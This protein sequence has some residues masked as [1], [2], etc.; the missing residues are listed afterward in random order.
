MDTIIYKIADF[1]DGNV[2]QTIILDFWVR[3][4]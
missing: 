2:T 4:Q 3:S 1:Q